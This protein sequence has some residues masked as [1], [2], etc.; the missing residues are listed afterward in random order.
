MKFLILLGILLI[1]IPAAAVDGSAVFFIKGV[2]VQDNTI[3]ISNVT[4]VNLSYRPDHTENIVEVNPGLTFVNTLPDGWSE[5]VPLPSGEYTAYLRQGNADQPEEQRF[6]IGEGLTRVVLL[7]AAYASGDEGCC[8][9]HNVTIVD[10]PGSIIHHQEINHTILHPA[11]TEVIVVVDKPA[12]TETIFHPAVIRQ[13]CRPEVN[14]TQKQ[15]WYY[16][17]S[18]G[19]EITTH[20]RNGVCPVF[21]TIF[22]RRCEERIVV[23]EEAWCESIIDTPELTETIHHPEVNH[24]ETL[25]VGEPWYEVIV[26]VPAWDEQVGAKTHEERVCGQKQVCPCGCVRSK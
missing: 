15:M 9:C 23:I 11:G 3:F 8:T 10:V 22:P 21:E 1:V 2:T 5:P 16:T 19:W 13:V 17:R 4:A 12:W 20:W 26:D 25:P 24:T 14:I 7:G 6:V 18:K